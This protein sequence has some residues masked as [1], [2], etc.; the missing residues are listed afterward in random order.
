MHI[1]VGSESVE[2]QHLVISVRSGQQEE[3]EVEP[4]S[5]CIL[6]HVEINSLQVRA[7]VLT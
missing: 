2:I 7:L 5:F 1:S 4:V 3:K 6:R